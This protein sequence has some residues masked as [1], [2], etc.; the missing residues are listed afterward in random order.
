MSK[1]F[2]S[3]R[4]KVARLRRGLTIKALGEKIDRTSRTISSY[5]NDKEVPPESVILK[6]SKV[7]NYPVNFFYAEELD[8]LDTNSVS[9]RSLSKMTVAQKN[10]AISAGQISVEFSH[11]LETKLNLPV[12]QV[13]EYR[14]LSPAAAAYAIRQEWQLGELSISNMI[15]LLESKGIRVFSLLHNS[16]NIDAFSFWKDNVPFVF[17]NHQKS[18]E[19]SRFD[20]AHELGH[21][22]MHKHAKPQGRE[23]ETQADSFASALLMPEGSVRGKAVYMPTL[24]T[25][26]KLK[27]NWKVSVSALVR[28]MK[29]LDLITD[30]YYQK[31]NIQMSQRK[32][33][34][35]EPFGIEHEKS[36]LLEKTFKLL[37]SQ[38]I[39]REKISELLLIPTS[40]LDNLVFGLSRSTKPETIINTPNLSI[41]K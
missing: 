20:A 6:A 1:E 13:P 9:F 26:I 21:L 10:I 39:S 16:K 8:E 22:I 32:M 4:F 38:G 28:R 37:W 35:K 18:G 3:N 36:L 15:H 7:L 17:L 30:W 24:D 5:E 14:D 11:W 41:V 23:A 27:S 40:D 25:M 33:L 29:D 2:N 31:M 12:I 19:R 34:Q